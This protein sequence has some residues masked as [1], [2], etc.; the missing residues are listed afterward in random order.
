MNLKV[1]ILVDK[2]GHAR[3]AD[4]GLT[5]IFLGNKSVI[6]SQGDHLATVTMWTAPEISEGGVMTKEG[7]VFMF[8][9]VAVE[10]CTRGGF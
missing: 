5:T 9:M 7:D 2:D 3:L 8:A 10:V 1:N 4:F 6:G